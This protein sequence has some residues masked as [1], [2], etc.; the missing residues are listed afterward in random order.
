MV[1]L[2][3]R[4]YYPLT[5]GVVA[6]NAPSHPGVFLLS[7]VLANGVHHAFFTSQSENIHQSLRRYVNSDRSEVPEE[8]EVYLDA[9]RCY[10]TFF[11]IPEIDYRQEIEKMLVSTVDPLTKLNVINCN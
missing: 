1:E 3:Q 5:A 7:I 11:I 4:G 8:L 6:S 10:F 9:Y 2:I